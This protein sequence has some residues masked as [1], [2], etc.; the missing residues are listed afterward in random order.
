MTG[1]TDGSRFRGWHLLKTRDFG[2]LWSGQLVSQ[3][4]D[5]LNKVALLWFVYSLTGSALKMTIIGLLQTVPALLF[6]PVIGVYLDRMQ[7]KWLMVW[8]DL[9]RT[10]LVLLI[11]VL[12][13]LGALTL[14]RIYVLVFLTAIASTTFGPAL[15]SSVPLIVA[16]PQLTAA[17]ALMQSGVNIAVLVGPAMSGVGIALIGEQNVLFINAGAYLVS[18]FCLLPVR[19]QS[20]QAMPDSISSGTFMSDILAGFRFVFLQERTILFLLVTVALFNLTWSGFLFLLPVVAQH[21]LGV[22][23]LELGWLWS[24]LGVGMLAASAWLACSEQRDLG[25]KLRIIAGS[26][27]VG[28]LA[29]GGLR[30]FGN[31]MFAAPLIIIIGGCIAMVTPVVWALLQEMTPN[32]MLARVFTTF[33]TG[34]MSAAMAGM[35]GFGWAVDQLG[36]GVTLLGIGVILLMAALAATYFSRLLQPAAVVSPAS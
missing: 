32:H 36:S 35:L 17:N 33:S 12:Y 23:P 29:V 16:R 4:G 14:E 3:I 1:N 24:F 7:K 13:S 21:V 28:G 18:A 26:M 8:I 10:V 19:I 2:F 6:A 30:L 34:A 25:H 9:A 20:A 5:G 11:P 31:V 22:G 27:G 15:T